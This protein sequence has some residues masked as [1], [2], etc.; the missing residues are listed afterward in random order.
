MQN[1]A[2]LNALV[3]HMQEAAT[4]LI[5]AHK[6]EERVVETLLASELTKMHGTARKI[7]RAGGAADDTSA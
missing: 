5:A 2:V 1:A 7:H 4:P 3:L 6:L